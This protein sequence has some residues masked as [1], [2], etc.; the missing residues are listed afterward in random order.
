MSVCRLRM[1]TLLLSQVLSAVCDVL[2]RSLRL[3]PTTRYNV[4][5]RLFVIKTATE[6]AA[7]HTC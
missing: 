4:Y 3:H 7:V 6:G 5:L 1:V 2:D